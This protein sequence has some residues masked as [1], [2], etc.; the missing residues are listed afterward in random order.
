M[1]AV[2]PATVT[3]S[4]AP[5]RPRAWVGAHQVSTLLPTDFRHPSWSMWLIAYLARDTILGYAFFRVND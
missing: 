3:P 4:L 2:H 1:S 5:A